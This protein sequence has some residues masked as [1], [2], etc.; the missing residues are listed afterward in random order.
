MKAMIRHYNRKFFEEGDPDSLTWSRWY[1]PVIN[2]TEGLKEIDRYLQ[3]QFRFLSTGRYCKAN[4]RVDYATLKRLGYR[5]L[6]S[7]FYRSQK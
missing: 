2:R 5:S 1:F 6:V 4:F 7:E 3:Q